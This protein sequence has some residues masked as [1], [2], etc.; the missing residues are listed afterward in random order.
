MNIP[1]AILNRIAPVLKPMI[2]WYL[3]KT[4]SYSY[5]DMKVSVYPGVFHPGLFLS[6]KVLLEFLQQLKLGESSVLELGAGSGL[7]SVYCAKMGARVTASDI[8][9]TAIRNISDNARQNNIEIK[10]IKSD[11]FDLIN[12]NDFQLIIVNPPYYAKP[13]TSEK[14]F[15]WFCGENFEYFKKFFSQLKNETPL[16]PR[17]IMIL[18]E[19]CDKKNISGIASE[20]GFTLKEVFRRRK[21]GEWNYIF[22]ITEN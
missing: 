4:R 20:F 21:I 16:R 9:D 6:T 7:I 10:V 19:D 3:S 22:D 1:K 18:S 5:G 2:L 15:P 12:P 14:D 17:I 11:L 8:S 13:V